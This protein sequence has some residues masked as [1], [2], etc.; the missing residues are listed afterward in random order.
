MLLLLLEMNVRG[1]KPN[2]MVEGT[3][4][5]YRSRTTNEMSAPFVD[6]C[7]LLPVAC[8]TVIKCGRIFNLS[9]PHIPIANC[10]PS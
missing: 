4:T 6:L 8:A 3:S 9:P 2:Q 7:S 10:M 5:I 1:N